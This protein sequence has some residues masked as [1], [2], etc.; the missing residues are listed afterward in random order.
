MTI[1][2]LDLGAP[3]R[4]H[5]VGVGGAGMS[6]IASV[7]AAM[8]H[9]VTGSDLKSS[10]ATERLRASGVAVAIGH[11]PEHVG[12]AELVT[13]S[14]AVPEGNPEVL[15]ARRR[16]LPVLHRAETL[17]AIAAC[18]RCIAVAGTHGKTTTTSMLALVLVEAGMRPSFLVGGDINETGTNALW[19]DGE[20]LVLE[21][22][23]SDGTFLALDPEIAVI[24]NIEADHLDHYGD[25][26]ALEAAFDRFA[27][28][29]PGGVV[30]GADEPRAAALG[31]RH[32]ATSV[33]TAPDADYRIRAMALERHGARFELE[34]AGATAAT[35]TM[36][37]PGAHNVRNAAVALVAA[38]AAGAA[39]DD[40]VRALARYAGVARRFEAR[41]ELG[42]VHFVDDYAHLPTEVAAALA[43]ARAGGWDRVVAV[44][45]PHRYS[46]TAALGA[47]FADAFVDA[48]MVVLTD[49]YPAGERP[50]PGVS[51][52]LVAD[53]VVAAHPD[54]D[55][56]YVAGRAEL[57]AHL[58]E[59]LRPGDLCLTLGAGDI[60]ALADE[61]AAEGGW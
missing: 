60:T 41:G 61:L 16:G 43:A 59:V 14:S 56:T 24:T 57:R 10:P 1:R 23:E 58:R 48:D 18:R 46:R 28:G 37:V 40:G 38:C 39:F 13:V 47:A 44:F 35:V 53:A 17:A 55:V 31:R 11:A 29:R 2:G 52:R 8:G 32:G 26:D 49:V 50:V 15:E 20:W 36:P 4:I 12:E 25:L 27:S 19:D 5:V 51:G 9:S 42:G 3:R 54:A 34:H 22:D 6:A 33:G 21:A 45:Q 7:L 30:V